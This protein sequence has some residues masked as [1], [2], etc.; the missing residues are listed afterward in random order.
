MSLSRLAATAAFISISISSAAQ[1]NCWRPEERDAAKVR[2]L[3]TMLMVGTLHCRSRDRY[4]T[5]AYNR[6]VRKHRATLNEQGG[7]LQG[8]FERERAG[9]PRRAYDRYNTALANDFARQGFNSD[10]SCWSITSL[11]EEAEDSDSRDLLSLANEYVP[12]PSAAACHPAGGPVARSKLPV[13]RPAAPAP[14]PVEPIDAPLTETEPE[15]D[16]PVVQAAVE[17]PKALLPVVQAAAAEP[18]ALEPA[19]QSR[20]EALKLAIAALQAATAALEAAATPEMPAVPAGEVGEV[21]LK[22]PPDS[23]K[24]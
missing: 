23:G 7:V 1:A 24:E 8:H 20:D 19:A 18:E 4:A 12:A 13:V 11:A 17:K 6:F 15:V 5:A 2:A 10:D 21:D 3:Q 14:E 22:E 9:D 16:P